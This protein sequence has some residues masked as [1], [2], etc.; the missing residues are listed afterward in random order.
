MFNFTIH[1]SCILF[2]R[3]LLMWMFTVRTRTLS[4]AAVVWTYRYFNE[5]ARTH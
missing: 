3:P 1:V 5:T 4:R 2:Y